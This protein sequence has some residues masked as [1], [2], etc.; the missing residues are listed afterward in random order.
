MTLNHR[1]PR[2]DETRMRRRPTIALRALALVC[3]LVG[4]GVSAAP[5]V[6][7]MAWSSG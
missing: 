2:A 4:A 6:A 3:V 5:A 1:R 7:S